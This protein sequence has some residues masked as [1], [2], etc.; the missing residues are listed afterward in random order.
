MRSALNAAPADDALLRSR[1]VLV[2]DDDAVVRLVARRMLESRAWR[3]TEAADGREALRLLQP[4]P[5][6]VAAVVTDIEMPR[7]R[8]DELI[9]VLAVHRPQLGLVAMSGRSAGP[10][11]PSVPFLQKP[12]SCEA[13]VDALE[14]AILAAGQARAEAIQQA[15]D[16]RE[17][18]SVARMQ[19]DRAARMRDGVDLMRELLAH[20]A[21]RRR[22]RRPAGD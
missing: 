8:G 11:L 15:A 10:A 2:V 6:G 21:S 12:F 4:L 22:V 19:R 18:R 3:V 14:E 13:L 5:T 16:A 9:H 17:A 20:R 1:G 7:V